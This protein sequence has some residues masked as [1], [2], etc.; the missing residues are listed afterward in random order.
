MYNQ[1]LFASKIYCMLSKLLWKLRQYGIRG[2]VLSWIQAFLGSRSQRV[3]IDGEDSESI[4]VCY[5]WSPPR[6]SSGPILF[7]VYIND[8]PEEVCSQ[9]R[10]FADDTALYLIMEGKDDSNAL[11]NDLDNMSN[12]LR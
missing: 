9:V 3:V 1:S 10:L 7:L 4:P 2:H 6:F 8:L 5:I 11:Q 12:D